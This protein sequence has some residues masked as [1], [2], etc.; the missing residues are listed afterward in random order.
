MQTENRLKVASLDSSLFKERAVKEV[1][2]QF[3]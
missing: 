2:E 3:P 1:V